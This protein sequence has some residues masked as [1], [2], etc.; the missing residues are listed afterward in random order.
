MTLSLLLPSVSVRVDSSYNLHLAVRKILP[1]LVSVFILAAVQLALA[2]VSDDCARIP[3]VVSIGKPY[4][5]STV[6]QSYGI[7]S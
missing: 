5:Q 6:K 1:L 7:T 4:N 2:I 3:A